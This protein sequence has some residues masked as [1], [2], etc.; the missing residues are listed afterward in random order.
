MHDFAATPHLVQFACPECEQLTIDLARYRRPLPRRVRVEAS[1]G[2]STCKHCGTRWE[3]AWWGRGP[4]N[5]KIVRRGRRAPQSPAVQ[6][7]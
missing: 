5:R 3:W 1:V 7:A 2:T 4:S 6:S